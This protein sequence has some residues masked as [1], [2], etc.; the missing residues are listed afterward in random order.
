MVYPVKVLAVQTGGVSPIPGTQ[1]EGETDPWESSSD[2]RLH[3]APQ[4]H[5]T[6]TH[7]NWL[8]IKISNFLKKRFPGGLWCIKSTNFIFLH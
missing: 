6:H 7:T 5:S 3:T 2:L 8:K 1:W 4:G